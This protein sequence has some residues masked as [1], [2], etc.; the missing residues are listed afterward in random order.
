MRLR[1]RRQRIL[2]RH[3]HE[4]GHALG[5]R[6]RD[7]QSAPARPLAHHQP[8]RRSARRRPRA[9]RGRGTAELPASDAHR[10][11]QRARI[12]AR[13]RDDQRDEGVHPRHVRLAEREHLLSERPRPVAVDPH[14]RRGLL[15]RGPVLLRPR[16][17]HGR[18]RADRRHVARHG[19][20]S[21]RGDGLDLLP[22]KA[23]RRLRCSRSAHLRRH[24]RARRHDPEVNVGL[25]HRRGRA[26]QAPPH[27]LRGPALEDDLY[28]QLAARPRRIRACG[29]GARGASARLCA[30]AARA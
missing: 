3:G 17:G 11:P 9:S 7:H 18:R 21:E 28:E 2:P 27:R 10:G 1:G 20:Q 15:H 8:R 23:R 5:G 26:R 22:Q 14:G 25:A 24:A 13:R 19:R 16:A 29:Q 4:H 30:R 12:R 6:A